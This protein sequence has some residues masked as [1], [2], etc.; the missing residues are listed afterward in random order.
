VNKKKQKNF[1][2]EQHRRP[3]FTPDGGE[4]QTNKSLLVLFFKKE[5]LPFFLTPD[6]R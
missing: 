6:P 5:P 2:P 1:I 3:R 4:R